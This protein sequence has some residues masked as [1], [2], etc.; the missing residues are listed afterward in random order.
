M[1]KVQKLLQKRL[2]KAEIIKISVPVQPILRENSLMKFAG[3][4]QDDP[5]F[6]EIIKEIRAEREDNSD[7]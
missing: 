5:D 2:A 3:I 7:I 6:L 1:E 4:F